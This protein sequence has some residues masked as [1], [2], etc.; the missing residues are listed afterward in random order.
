MYT[1]KRNRRTRSKRRRFLQ[2]GGKYPKHTLSFISYGDDNFKG[3]KDRIKSEAEAMG[4]FDGQIKM[5]GPE[6]LSADFKKGVGDALKAPRGAGYWLWRPYILKDIMSKMKENDYV[7][8]ADAGCTLQPAGIPRL[9]EY[10]KMI[11]PESGKSLLCM[12]L[13]GLKEKEWTTTAIFDYFD[14]PLESEIGNANQILGGV[15]LY[16]K[17]PE[18]LAII[19][20]MYEIATT[21]P[22]LFTDEHNDESKQKNPMFKDNRHDQ[23]VFTIIVQTEP[24]SKTS[25]IIDEEVESGFGSRNKSFYSTKPVIASRK[26]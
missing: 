5:Y 20:K 21:R 26:K 8:Y 6:D 12:R 11:S 23:S 9:K 13:V 18:S 4:C 25:V 22:D 19:E 17:C 24:Y 15:Q 3:S 1:K 10:I 16:R 14:I 2:K 7:L